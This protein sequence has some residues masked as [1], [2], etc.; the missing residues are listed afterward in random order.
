MDNITRYGA[1]N[2]KIHAM[3]GDFLK[4]EDYKNMLGKSSV[5]EVITYL[6]QNTVYGK[7]LY[8]QTEG[9]SR[10]VLEEALNKSMIARI[11]KLIHY[12]TGSYREFIR[13]LYMKYE[14][15]DLKILARTI[16]NEERPEDIDKPL[17]FIGK[18]SRLDPN[19]ILEAN[20]IRDLILSMDKT[21]LFNELKPVID[22][23]RE[24]LFYFEMALDMGY[25]NILK[26][27][28]RKIS[29]NDRHVMEKW[30]GMVAD[31]YNVQWIYRGKKFYNLL[32]EEL[33]NYTINFG[34]KLSF[35]DRKQ[36]C[37][38][39]NLDDLYRMTANLGYGFLFNKENTKDIFMERRINRYIFYNLKTMSKK[40]Q[41]SIIK[42][43][44]FIWFL[45]FEV[46]D[47]VSII[48]SIRY[49]IPAEQADKFLI[50]AVFE[51]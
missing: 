13:T 33:L 30:E 41:M 37:Y 11:D 16:F 29:E 24:N 26:K 34:E 22:M 18:Y 27:N 6:K 44:A 46:R 5:A 43:V 38:I 51:E 15:E 20:S 19:K 25:F 48:E 21:E 12:F 32:P 42:T 7:M 1:I 17:T 39:E 3:E 23:K 40:Y 10:R 9:I 50:K 14:I 31:L 49:K 8:V 36:M 35:S 4:R 45:E 28:W 2:T 47:I